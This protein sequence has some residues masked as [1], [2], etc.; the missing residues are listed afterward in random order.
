MAKGER[1]TREETIAALSLYVQTPFG[2]MHAGNSE[3]IALAERLGRTPSSVAMKLCNLASLDPVERA[4]GVSGM[5]NV[6]RLDREVWTEYA[7]RW[8][9]LAATQRIGQAF[10][11]RAVLAAW[12]H[13]CAVTGL[14]VAELLRASH[15]VPWADDAPNRLTPRNGLCL[16]ALHDAAFD[17]GLMTIDS[18]MQVVYARDLRN[19]LKRS[20]GAAFLR[21]FEGATLRAPDRFRPEDAFFEHHRTRVFVDA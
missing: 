20:D 1:W 17:R 13:S 4:R 21:E 15:I 6:S 10:F 2:R 3:I 8:S 14:R 18:S 11:R 19:A 7:D 16:N 5:G 12:D 9:D